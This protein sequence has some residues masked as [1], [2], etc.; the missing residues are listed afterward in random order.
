MSCNFI[1]YKIVMCTSPLLLSIAHS[2]IRIINQ[3]KQ[4]FLEML[5]VTQLVKGN[6]RNIMEPKISLSH[7]QKPKLDPCPEHSTLSHAISLRS[8]LIVSSSYLPM[9]S[10]QNFVYSLFHYVPYPPHPPNILFSTPLS[11][12]PKFSLSVFLAI[13]KKDLPLQFFLV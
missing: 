5:I 7:S 1:F 13:V 12:T 2:Y 6:S 9:S 11:N 4:V 10:S 3:T 8:I